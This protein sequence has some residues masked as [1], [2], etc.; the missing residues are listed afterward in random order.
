LRYLVNN[1]HQI[2]FI[3]PSNGEFMVYIV[4]AWWH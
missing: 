2:T 1:D 3:S 4:M